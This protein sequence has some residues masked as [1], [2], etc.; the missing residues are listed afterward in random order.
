MIAPTGA[1]L[2][3]GATP[4]ALACDDRVKSIGN[5]IENLSIAPMGQSQVFGNSNR[6]FEQQRHAVETRPAGTGAADTEIENPKKIE[7][8]P[9]RRESSAE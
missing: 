5:Q 2:E 8:A 1:A 9:L 3:M 7:G 6:E 4:I